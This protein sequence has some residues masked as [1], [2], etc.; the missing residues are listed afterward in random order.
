MMH[1]LCSSTVILFSHFFQ[2]PFIALIKSENKKFNGRV[3]LLAAQAHN[4]FLNSSYQLSGLSS[5]W[6]RGTAYHLLRPTQEQLGRVFYFEDYNFMSSLCLKGCL[7]LLG[8]DSLVGAT[9]RL[10]W[11]LN[12]DSNPAFQIFLRIRDIMPGLEEFIV[13]GKKTSISQEP[14]ISSLNLFVISSKIILYA[15]Q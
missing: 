5:F 4:L 2:N 9:D 11:F 8:T 6:E 13:C 3:S 12:A 15:V 1:C 7:N 10:Y 14:N